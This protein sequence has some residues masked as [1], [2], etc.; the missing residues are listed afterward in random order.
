MITLLNTS[1]LINSCEYT[2]TPIPAIV[3]KTLVE[4]N[5]EFDSV[6]SGMAPEYTSYILNGILNADI[7]EDKIEYSDEL[8]EIVLLAKPT[9]H[10]EKDTLLAIIE[11]EEN[12]FIFWLLTKIK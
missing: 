12:E 2:Y 9:N 6:R 8:G 3:A 4:L 7:P 11:A 1:V 10:P 5:N